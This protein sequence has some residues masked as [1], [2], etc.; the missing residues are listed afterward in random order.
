MDLGHSPRTRGYIE[1][2]SAFITS[3]SPAGAVCE[4]SQV[5]A[6][7]PRMACEVIDMAIQLHGVVGLSDDFQL[8]SGTAGANAAQDDRERGRAA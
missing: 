8:A 4:L 5:K 7:V 2:A 6:V 3:E 1:L